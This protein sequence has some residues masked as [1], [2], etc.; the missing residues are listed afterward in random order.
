VTARLLGRRTDEVVIAAATA[1]RF[2]S[3]SASKP[4]DGSAV[5][6]ADAIVEAD[7]NPALRGRSA[8]IAYLQQPQPFTILMAHDQASRRWV[9]GTPYSPEHEP[10]ETFTDDRVAEMARAPRGCPT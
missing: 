2:G 10:L 8:T 7:L 4:T 6:H 3:T 5:P 1:A 9:F